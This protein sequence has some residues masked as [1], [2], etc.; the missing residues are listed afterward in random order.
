MHANSALPF[1][2][3]TMS[4]LTPVSFQKLDAASDSFKNLTEKKKEL[5]PNCKLTKKGC[6]NDI[7]VRY[8]RPKGKQVGFRVVTHIGVRRVEA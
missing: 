5:C 2:F 6:V 3:A 1:D 4:F 8:I 7:E